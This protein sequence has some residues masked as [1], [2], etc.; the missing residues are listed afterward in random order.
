MS[1]FTMPIE[2]VVVTSTY[3]TAKKLPI[4]YISHDCD[5]E[6]GD[7]WQFHSGNGDFAMDKLQ[8]V[9]LSTILAIDST[10]EDAAD[11]PIGFCAKREAI[12]RP[13]VFEPVI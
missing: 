3:V 11:L 12:G 6:E 13:W 7:S 1:G 10:V 9:R 8:L 2:T 5:E 4:L